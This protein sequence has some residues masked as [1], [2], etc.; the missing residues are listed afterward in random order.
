[1][2]FQLNWKDALAST[3]AGST[4][5]VRASVPAAN[6]SAPASMALLAA[7]LSATASCRRPL[8]HAP[9]LDWSG[10]PGSAASVWTAT[11]EPGGCHLRFVFSC[12]DKG[13]MEFVN[14]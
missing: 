1:M 9:T 14:F 2:S 5:T 11:A 10:S 3:T 12:T 6:I 7:L 4:R 8:R 13:N